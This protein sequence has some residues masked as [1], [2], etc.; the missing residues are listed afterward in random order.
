MDR[1]ALRLIQ[2]LAETGH[3][4]RAAER[5]GMAQPH[6]STALKA[7]EDGLGLRLFDRRPNV[8]LTPQG[9]MVLHALQRAQGEIDQAVR[10]AR[11]LQAGA[12]G[13]L[14]V[15]FA[16]SVML[17]RL[18]A[19]LQAFRQARPDIE[20]GLLDLHSGQQWEALTSGR[21][22]VALTREIPPAPDVVNRLL[23]RDALV[24]VL[25]EG[26][27]LARDLGPVALSAAAGEPFVMFRQ[28]DA[29]TL[30]AEVLTACAAA[31]FALEVAQEA[32][33]WPAI[34]SLVAHGFGLS[35]APGCVQTLRFPGLAFRA[36]SD[37]RAIGSIFLSH[38]AHRLSPAA[39]SFAEFIEARAGTAA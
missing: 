21:I 25:P 35:L 23:L 22:D 18:A 36:L 4:G 19:D 11:R 5:L 2:A 20:L 12:A 29:P 34:L 27:A 1:R 8:R 30:Y 15:G 6:L 33:D 26:H 10:H 31:G 37:V 16:S 14:T 7:L 24:L 17:T 3:F 32:G 28:A 38:P 39:R 13:A 9:E